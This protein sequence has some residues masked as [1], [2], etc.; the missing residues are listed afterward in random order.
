[1]AKT[2]NKDQS[3]NTIEYL[4]NIHT[5]LLSEIHKNKITKEDA[6]A[7]KIQTFLRQIKYIQQYGQIQDGKIDFSSMS[8]FPFSDMWSKMSQMTL[9][10]E[11]YA[12][13]SHIFEYNLLNKTKDF[14]EEVQ[15]S[16][17]G[18]YLELGLVQVLNTLES[19]VTGQA[20]KDVKNK[21]Q[22]FRVGQQ[23][24]QIPDLI[25]SVDSI[26]KEEFH[27]AY[28]KTQEALKQ[29]KNDSSNIATFMPSVEGKIDVVGYTA[30][31]KVG[32]STQLSPYTRSILSALKGA[33]FTAKNYI[34]TREL[35]FGQTN[36]FRIF[37]TVAPTGATTVARFQ[38]MMH[39]FESHGYHSEGPVLFYRIKAIYELTGVGMQYKNSMFNN[40]FNGA[41]AKFLVWNNPFGDIYVIPTQRIIDELIEKAAEESLPKNWQDALYG[42]VILPQIDIASLAST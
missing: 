1:M 4:S 20:Y 32:G 26:M 2:L 36:P 17:L 8:N 9:M 40:I 15:S 39:C 37:A 19:S 14:G 33:T 31:I 34:S 28:T 7:L 38:R 22:T 35:K 6:Q 29:Y 42:P 11:L 3:I 24:T 12:A 21:N 27:A 18:S 25:S 16:K 41:G 5:A 13:N 23:H 10:N 30:S